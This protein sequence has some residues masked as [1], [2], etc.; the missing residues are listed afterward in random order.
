MKTAVLLC[1]AILIVSISAQNDDNM[2]LNNEGECMGGLQWY[3]CAPCPTTCEDDECDT[4]ELC[5]PG[6]FCPEGMVRHNDM[7]IEMEDCPM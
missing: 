6:C 5:I 1:C 3:D 7:C 4:D 2:D